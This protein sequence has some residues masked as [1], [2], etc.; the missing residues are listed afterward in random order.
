M[1]GGMGTGL[2][3]SDDAFVDVS[4]RRTVVVSGSEAIAWLNDLVSAEL[5]TLGPGTACR[6]LLLSPTGGILA[7][8][9]VAVIGGTVVLLQDPAQPRSIATLLEPYVLS[10]D[11]RLGDRTGGYA[12][13]AFPGRTT[14]PDAPGT[15]SSA[16]SCLGAGVDVVSLRADH[17]RL[18][19]SFGR[20][21]MRATPDDLEAWRI[22]SGIPRVGVDTADG[23]LPQEA[24]LEDAVSFDKGCFLGQEAVAKMRNLGHPRRWVAALEGEG[25]VPPGERLFADDDETG[26][27]TSVAPSNGTTLALARIRWEHRDAVLRTARD[28]QL[29]PRIPARRM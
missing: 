13:F 21:Y 8:F 12:I 3:G 10:S 19:T 2:L 6:S 17:D 11:V 1:G 4:D 23:D 28:V 20:V 7:E 14:A 18:A 26:V 15:E 16:P 24:R 25:S 22:A 29:R 27:V 9:T 5:D